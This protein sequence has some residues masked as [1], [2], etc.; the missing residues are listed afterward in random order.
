V[1]SS[2]YA[3]CPC[4]LTVYQPH[5]RA[6]PEAAVVILGDGL[7]KRCARRQY[8][9]IRYSCDAGIRAAECGSHIQGSQ[10]AACPHH[11]C[12]FLSCFIIMRFFRFSRLSILR[13]VR[14]SCF[15][16]WRFFQISRLFFFQGFFLLISRILGFSRFF[17][18]LLNTVVRLI[19]QTFRYRHEDFHHFG[20][21][22]LNPVGQGQAVAPTGTVVKIPVNAQVIGVVSVP[23]GVFKRLS[24]HQPG[25]QVGLTLHLGHG[26]VLVGSIGGVVRGG[27]IDDP[28]RIIDPQAVQHI[29]Q[30]GAC[31]FNRLCRWRCRFLS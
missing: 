6:D 10:F 25:D 22:H 17:H 3:H 31:G 5:R 23:V 9:S 20:F 14:F 15:I 29:L 26:D 12:F 1:L 11:E 13:G 4:G 21:S 30:Q 18:A 8:G 7:G 16:V 28:L 27:H 19:V 2:R 24:V